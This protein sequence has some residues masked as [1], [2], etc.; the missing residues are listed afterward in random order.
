[1]SEL[2]AWSHTLHVS[3]ALTWLADVFTEPAGELVDAALT[4]LLPPLDDLFSSADFH[5]MTC[6]CEIMLV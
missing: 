2:N 5:Y 3:T 1:L 4:L 6:S